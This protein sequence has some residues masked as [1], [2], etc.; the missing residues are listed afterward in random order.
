[1]SKIVF[2][3]AIRNLGRT[4]LRSFFTFFSVALI[5]M[6]Y[7]ILT[8]V[9]N[10]FTKQISTVLNEQNID[11]VVQA[12]YAVTPV[13]SIIKDKTVKKLLKIDE[14]DRYDSI[15]IGRKRIG[16]RKSTFILGV[17]NFKIFSQRLGLNIVRGKTLGNNDNE[18]LV[19]VKIAQLLNLN[20]GDKF[21]LNSDKDYVVVG[22]Y[23]SWLNL[24]NSSIL[25]NLIDVQKLLKRPN[26]ISM[27]FLTLKDSRK[28]AKVLNEIN[29]NFKNLRAIESQQLP[30]DLGPLKSVFYFSRIVSI[31]TVVIAVFV[32]LNTF[33][34]AI[35]ERTKE[36]G[37]LFAIGWSRKIIIQIFLVEALMLSFAG[38]LLGFLFSF[39]VMYLIQ[40]Y[41]TNIS[42]YLPNS[43][44]IS[45]LVNVFFMCLVIGI[46]SAI[47]PALYG[48]K[49]E[50]AKALR[51]E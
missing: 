21:K 49:L 44:D 24:L 42:I 46:L 7:T 14:I 8:S 31:L 50:V 43:L 18:V 26:Q 9:G 51:D 41:F 47:F 4:R 33:A 30:N 45:V 15:L 16:T 23:S 48:T 13:S 2:L 37:I 11:I 34:M 17:S 1:M 40:K 3:Y 6:L 20:I 25:S 5:I 39:P 22:L 12:K 29:V 38:G 19:G 35:N 28:T 10:S 32:L 27:I 36:I